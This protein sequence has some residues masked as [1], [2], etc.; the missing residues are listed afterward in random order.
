MCIHARVEEAQL[1]SKDQ[2]EIRVPRFV[3]ASNLKR[4]SATNFLFSG[5]PWSP[6]YGRTTRCTW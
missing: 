4:E 5:S 2:M 3:T 6:R 1:D